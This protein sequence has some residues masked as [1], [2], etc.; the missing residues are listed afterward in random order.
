MKTI[1]L[2]LLCSLGLSAATVSITSISCAAG[3]V[4]VA[5]A[6]TGLVAVQG[7]EITG[8]TGTAAATYNL[9]GTAATTSSAGFTFNLPSGTACP[10]GTATGG[11]VSPAQ[12]IIVVNITPLNGQ[13]MI[14]YILWLTTIVPVPCPTCTSSFI[15]AN[16][17]QLAAIQAGT[18]IE[19]VNQVALPPA[20][21]AA[22]AVT[23]LNAQYIAAQATYTSGLAKY[24]GWCCI[25]T[26]CTSTC[27]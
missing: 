4:T 27:P 13:L 9:N 7:F 8:V 14:G 12:Q 6:N 3:V 23:A 22:Q 16:P 15:G 10:S 11:S 26:T 20:E 25:G 17:A 1:Y 5:A 2:F 19:V 18:T 24:A 21:T